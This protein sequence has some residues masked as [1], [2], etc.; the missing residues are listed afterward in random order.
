[1]ILQQLLNE[2]FCNILKFAFSDSEIQNMTNWPIV[3]L[4]I[5]SILALQSNPNLF[6]IVIGDKM[7]LLGEQKKNLHYWNEISDTVCCL[8]NMDMRFW[9]A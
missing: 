8:V 4:Y 6:F 1:M 9:S 3:Y 2:R 5:F 7:L